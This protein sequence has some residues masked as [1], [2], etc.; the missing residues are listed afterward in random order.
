MDKVGVGII[1]CGA[2]SPAYMSNM[3]DDFSGLL[4]MVACADLFPEAAEKRAREFGIPR[5]C[6]V[7][8]LMADPA[9]ELVVN[10][11]NPEGHHPVTMAAFKAGKHVFTEKPLGITMDEGREI[12]ETAMNTGRV[13]A[14]AADIF[15]GSGLQMSRKLVD[16]GRIG[17]PLKVTDL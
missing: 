14:G 6:T 12:V 10:L 5:S 13:L 15:L 16:E 1:G 2:I 17:T 8:E 9:V 3:R 4:E 11:T 7:D